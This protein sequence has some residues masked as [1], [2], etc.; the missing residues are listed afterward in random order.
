MAGTEGK[1]NF[2]PLVRSPKQ[3]QQ[4]EARSPELHAHLYMGDRYPSS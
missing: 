2:H 1:K 4:C 3:L